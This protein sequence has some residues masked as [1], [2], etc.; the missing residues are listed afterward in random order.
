MFC[1]EKKQMSLGLGF[2]IVVTITQVKKLDRELQFRQ[3][4]KYF[5]VTI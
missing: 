5:F 3:K 1:Q 2:T 4:F